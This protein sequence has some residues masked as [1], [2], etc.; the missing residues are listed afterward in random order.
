MN[1]TD[2][3][4]ATR[5]IPDLAKKCAKG[6]ATLDE[7]KRF[8][9]MNAVVERYLDRE[10]RKREIFRPAIWL[11]FLCFAFWL[12]GHV[13][14]GVCAFLIFLALAFTCGLDKLSVS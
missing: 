8:E 4:I 2:V 10:A 7:V 5:D 9:Q 6:T 11:T 3:E 13:P 14:D 12:P 1:W